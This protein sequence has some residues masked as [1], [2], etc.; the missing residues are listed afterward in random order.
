MKPAALFALTLLPLR[1]DGLSD[2]KAA[3]QRLK[4][5]G[6]LAAQAQVQT[7]SREG[8]KKAEPKVGG[9]T[10]R[11]EDGP[12]GLK[13]GWTP[14]QLERLA[15]AKGKKAKD[16]ETA[17]LNSLDAAEALR[18]VRAAEDLL[19]E[20]EEASQLGEQA[21]TWE[22]H[23][24][25]KLT[26]NMPLG[27][28]E[29]DRKIFKEAKSVATV[30]IAGDGTPLAMVHQL[31]LKGRVMLISFQVHTKAQRRYQAHQG[32]LLLVKED[33]EMSGSGMGK[34]GEGRTVTTL[35]PEA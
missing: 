8:G 32:R 22:G 19:G 16:G 11:L 31:D 24:A 27:Q 4:G 2:L 15:A 25:R 35:V 33:K 9:A 34:S 23:P 3:L 17:A 13:L 1:A 5:R 28:D 21:E 30:W 12:Q 6:P 18:L 29:E 7:W 26:L 10:V 20:L 14:A